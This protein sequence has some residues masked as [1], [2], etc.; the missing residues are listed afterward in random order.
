MKIRLL[1]FPSA[2]AGA[3]SYR[4]WLSAFPADVEVI[5]VELPGRGARIKEA[6]YS[7]ARMLANTLI[8]ELA[9]Y[10]E[11][12]YAMFGHSVG[13]LLA[14]EVARA[15]KTDPIHLFVSA[16]HSPDY[17]CA[18]RTSHDL[19]DD[20]LC[21]ELRSMG[22]MSEI[23]LREPDIMRLLLPAIRADLSMTETYLP[24]RVPFVLQCPITAYAGT[25]DGRVL[26][27]QMEGWSRYTSNTFR[28]HT[29]HGGHFYLQQPDC[30]L[31]SMIADSLLCS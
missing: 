7:D 13:A 4:S 15:A 26:P 6:L 23:L 19:P 30:P 18:A 20:A 8:S 14:Y 9:S 17:L 29:M 21:Q 5:P 31:V 3:L 27:A 1:C 16:R 22:G 11:R 24:D 25:N 28:L 12:P 10:L 2:G